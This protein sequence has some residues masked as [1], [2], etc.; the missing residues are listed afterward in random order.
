M[1]T[2]PLFSSVDRLEAACSGLPA[3]SVR[4]PEAASL[5]TFLEA[6]LERQRQLA[7][8]LPPLPS[9]AAAAGP[10]WRAGLREMAATCAHHGT[11][12]IAAAAEL[13][14]QGDEP[15]LAAALSRF[16][17]R[18]EQDQ[19]ERLVVMAFLGGAAAGMAQQRDADLRD[20]LKPH[21]PTCGMPP[22]VS[23]LA[24]VDEIDGCRLLYCGVCHTAWPFS[25]TT[26]HCCNSNDD[27]QFDY[28]H[29]EGD[30][31]VVIQACRACREY[32]KVIDLRHYSLSLPE[33]IDT[34]TV[35]LDL[36]AVEQGFG[37]RFPSIFGY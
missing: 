15:A 25:R 22:V 35:A 2:L 4:F 11:P 21:C 5:L 23:L 20:W 29:P 33:I 26:C 6:V 19:V 12:E 16:I 9:L 32:L 18:E 7:S 13:L 3:L 31:S 28:L 37:K 27:R 10:P 34:A 8:S 14:R 24:D 30:L 17:N 36:H 1:T